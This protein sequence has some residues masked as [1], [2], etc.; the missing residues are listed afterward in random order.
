MNK[1]FVEYRNKNSIELLSGFA[2]EPVEAIVSV[3]AN[4]IDSNGKKD[5]IEKEYHLYV[6]EIVNIDEIEKKGLLSE[7]EI[8]CLREKNIAQLAKTSMGLKSLKSGDSVVENSQKL[9]NR[10][11]MM[12]AKLDILGYAVPE[13]NKKSSVR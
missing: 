10:V 4:S 6:G 5:F 11:N 3:Y 9:L 2:D 7:E 8:R 1:V 12:L 13:V